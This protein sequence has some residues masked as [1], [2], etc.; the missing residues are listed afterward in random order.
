MEP[1]APPLVLDADDQVELLRVARRAIAHYLEQGQFLSFETNRA[2][3]LEPAGAFVTLR[4]ASRL[5]GCIGTFEVDRPL[6]DVV[7]RMAVASATNDPRFPPLPFEQLPDVVIEISV[8]GARHPAR[9]DEVIVGEH[10]IHLQQGSYRGV[11]L[12]QV[13]LDNNWTRE[14]FL[15]GTCRKAGLPPDAWRDPATRLEVFSAQVFEEA[16]GDR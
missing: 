8:L 4:I 14:Q 16:E 2:R 5:R 1:Q 12:P 9:P 3:L 6:L 11:L 7:G 13:A 15:A 10:G